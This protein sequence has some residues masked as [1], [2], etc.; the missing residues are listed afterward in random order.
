MFKKLLITTLAFSFAFLNLGNA[1]AID[2]YITVLATGNIKVKPDT[3]RINATTSNIA[4]SSKI[5]LINTSA[6]SSKVRSVL[7]SNSIAKNYIKSSA[8][9][10]FPEYNY[11]AD[12]GSVLVGYKASQTFEIIVRNAASAGKLVDALVGEVGD[13]LTIDGVTPYVFDQSV[14]S[15]NARVAAV[16]QARV[17]ATS[18]AKLLGVQLGK[19]I[20][21]EESGATSQPPVM[22]SAAK[23]D[24]GGTVVDLGTQDISVN[25]STKWAI[26]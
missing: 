12:K 18:Y 11:T 22:M 4:D 23:S 9:T 13:G 5:A 2:R 15:A 1:Q 16:K 7:S 24:S 26:N 8:I 6:L 20:N 25:I 3:V 10:V 19:I 17:K 14:A 21:L